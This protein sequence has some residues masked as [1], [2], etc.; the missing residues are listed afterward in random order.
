M[1]LIIRATEEH[2]SQIL[3]IG[4]TAW[5][6]THGRS[7]KKEDIDLYINK[8][9]T[10]DAL[11]KELRDQENIYHIIYHNNE[12]AGFS[13]L[14]LNKKPANLKLPNTASLDRIYL[15]KDFHG[16]RLGLELF[17]F[18]RDYAQKEKQTGIWLATW[19]E[20]SK[21]IGF[22]SKIGFEIV[23]KYDFQISARHSNPNYIMFLSF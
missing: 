9:Y 6:E 18:N 22:Y 1:T 23:G 13:K 15:S 14:I 16:K 7:A 2:S 10:E 19:I 8:H 4:K 20:N 17:T 12:P 3:K 5:L 21:A 11:K